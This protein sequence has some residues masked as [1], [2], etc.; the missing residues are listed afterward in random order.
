ME[1]LDHLGESEFSTNIGTRSVRAKRVPVTKLAVRDLTISISGT[2][3][4]SSA[5]AT[6]PR[7]N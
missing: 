3:A 5:A 4:I 1:N 2:P 7:K 6:S